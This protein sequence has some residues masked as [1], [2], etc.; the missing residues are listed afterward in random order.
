MTIPD[1]DVLDAVAAEAELDAPEPLA[2][3]PADGD[4]LDR[5][6]DGVATAL[7]VFTDAVLQM[8]DGVVGS[9]GAFAGDE[10]PV[11]PVVRSRPGGSGATE[12]WLHNMAD[13]A[14][15]GVVLRLTRCTAHDGT[16]LEE[17]GAGFDPPKLDLAAGASERVVL[18]VAVPDA[19]RPGTY[20]GHV[21]ASGLPD[22]A[23][24]VRVV[25]VT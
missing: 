23:L 20:L 1:E 16:E 24:T 6:R 5:L 2:A 3:G 21:L 12:L 22:A 9:V 17:T 15:D 8:V 18:T 25:V 14:V 11:P 19:A 7:H 13:A 4:P 10:Q